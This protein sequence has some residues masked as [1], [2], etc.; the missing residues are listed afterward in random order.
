MLVSSMGGDQQRAAL[1]IMQH[2]ES[3]TAQDFSRSPDQSTWDERIGVDRLAVSVNIEDRNWVLCLLWCLL[4]QRSSKAGERFCQGSIDSK[5]G[6][7]RQKS[8]SVAIP[9]SS[10]PTGQEC[11]SLT[12]VATQ[13]PGSSQSHGFQKEQGQELTAQCRRLSAGQTQRQRSSQEAGLKGCLECREE[14]RLM[15]SGQ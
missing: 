7:L 2:H 11:Q 6:Q 5:R 9:V 3:A 1:L 14:A 10:M 13:I 12:G 4:P 8:L 15:G